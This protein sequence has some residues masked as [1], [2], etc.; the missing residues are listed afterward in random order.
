[1]KELCHN[2]FFAVFGMKLWR[3]LSIMTQSLF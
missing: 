2:G 1:M 3:E